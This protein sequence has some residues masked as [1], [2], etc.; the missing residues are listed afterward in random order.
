MDEMVNTFYITENNKNI[1]L[2][3][4]KHHWAT[5]TKQ[6][7]ESLLQNKKLVR[8]EEDENIESTPIRFLPSGNKLRILNF[9]SN[10]FKSDDKSCYT[11]SNGKTQG[12]LA[13]I[14]TRQ[15]CS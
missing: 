5:I 10:R 7:M 3:F 9:I 8:V 6:H 11:I 14:H 2:Y 13:G 15:Y 4:H 12:H 1:I